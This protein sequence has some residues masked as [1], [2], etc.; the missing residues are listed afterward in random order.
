MI[1]MQNKSH[2]EIEKLCEDGKI[3]RE[4]AIEVHKQHNIKREACNDTEAASRKMMKAID[5]ISELE[6]ER[7]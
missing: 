7:E 5:I 6:K 3:T 1:H 4:T 2:R